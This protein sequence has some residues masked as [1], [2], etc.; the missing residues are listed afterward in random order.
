MQSSAVTASLSVGMLIAI[1]AM[2]G[3]VSRGALTVA[4]EATGGATELTS[5]SKPDVSDAK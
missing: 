3:L 1:V 5:S 2:G 4:K